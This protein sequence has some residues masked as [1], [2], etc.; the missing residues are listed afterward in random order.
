[1]KGRRGETENYNHK[2]SDS[3]WF[4]GVSGNTCTGH[5]SHTHTH[6]HDGSKQ[7]DFIK[8]DTTD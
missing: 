8:M 1:M 5:L 4:L 2:A 6:T 7:C 3:I